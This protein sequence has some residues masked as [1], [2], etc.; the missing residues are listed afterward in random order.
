MLYWYE[1]ETPMKSIWLHAPPSIDTSM[2]TPSETADG[3]VH[4]RFTWLSDALVAVR[5]VICP[6]LCGTVYVR[7]AVPSP[8]EQSE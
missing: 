8:S 1:V 6:A 3:I 4:E 5:P 2:P 7:A